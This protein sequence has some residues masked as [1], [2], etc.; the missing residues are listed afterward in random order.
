[1]PTDYF[2]FEIRI[3]NMTLPDCACIVL[4]LTFTGKLHQHMLAC[5]LALI[6][7]NV[8]VLLLCHSDQC[9]SALFEL[10]C[11]AVLSLCH[12]SS[13]YTLHNVKSSA[14]SSVLTV[15]AKHK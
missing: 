13:I 4:Y 1:M 9:T 6:C 15:V 7:R 14:F 12:C 10:T 3:A 2:Y 5:T 11:V 8:S